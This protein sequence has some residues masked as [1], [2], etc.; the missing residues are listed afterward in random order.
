MDE[1]RTITIKIADK[2][3]SF[4]MLLGSN[5]MSDIA[6][7]WCLDS[8]GACEPEVCHLMVRAVRP[9]DVAIDG[10]ANIGFFTLLLSRLV[11]MEG[12]VIAIEPAAQNVAKLV[13]NIKINGLHNI[14]FYKEALWSNNDEVDLWTGMDSGISSLKRS[15]DHMAST[16]MNG[17]V[18]RD[19]TKECRLIKLDIEGS[20]LAALMGGGQL[21]KPEKCPFVVCEMN[22]YCMQQF[23]Y[24]IKDIRKF[25]HDRGY[26][27]FLL[28]ADGS[29]PA[30]VTRRTEITNDKKN[31]NVL[32]STPQ[33]V[34]EA[35][36]M[37]HF[38][39]DS[40]D[41]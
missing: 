5:S 26:D 24:S 39:D 32:F 35:W 41:I 6:T 4:Q 31:L 17:S 1:K 29:I 36:P 37:I 18:L 19:F 8:F 20:E 13:E 16:R 22:P 7:R 14:Q 11:G 10:G 25:M 2:E 34:A 33:A 15:P 23:G 21:I 27:L 28:R 9:G 38:Q 12:H 30:W 3:I 40:V